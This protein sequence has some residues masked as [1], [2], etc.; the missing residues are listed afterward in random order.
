MVGSLPFDDK[1]GCPVGYHKRASYTSKLGHRV[2]PR[3]VKAQTVYA[4]SRKNY[5]HRVLAKQQS[6]LKS[7][8]KPLTSRIRC[9]DGEVLRK[10]YVRRFEKN[11]LN[12]GYT[13]KR[14]SGKHY[15]IYPERATVYVKPVCVKDRGLAGHGPGPGQ[16]F[17]P[18]RKGELKKH[19]YVYDKQQSER[20]TAL[21][22]AVEEFGAL[23]VF[24]KLDAVAKLS[25]RAAPEASKIFKAD[26]NWIESN[27]KLR[28]P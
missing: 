24:R 1:K 15:R 18:L 7:M 19:G 16:S 13:V 26:R 9:P 14:K 20:H 6:R 21:K 10:G 23:G 22:K 12:K 11:V 4:E 27:Y 28:L 3:C 8:G 5:T 25:K 2:H 17:G